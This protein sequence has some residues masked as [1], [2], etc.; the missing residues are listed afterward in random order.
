MAITTKPLQELTAEDV[1]TYEVVPLAETMP[2]REAARLLVG[3][4]VGGAPVVDA[5]GRC[6]GVL[7]ATDFV[8]LAGR[9]ADATQPAAPPLPITCAF[10]EKHR[11][12]DGKEVT[13]CTLPA[14]ACPMQ[15]Q[16]TDAPGEALV[17]CSQP[18]CVPVDWQ[19]VAV[20]DLPADEVRRFMTADPVVA[21]PDTGIRTLARMMIDA[22]IHRVIVVDEEQKPVGV[23]SSTDLLAALAYA[24]APAIA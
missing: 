10:Q 18:H 12:H 3:N 19:V 5:R 7:S 14:G 15:R 9:R 6:V 8:R 11:T 24:D 21:R 13:L 16:Q 4:R 22:H 17:I 23:V 1:M 2:L 20:E